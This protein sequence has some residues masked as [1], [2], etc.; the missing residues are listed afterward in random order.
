MFGPS[1]FFQNV[2]DVHSS[3]SSSDFEILHDSAEGFNVLYRTCRNGRFFV[4]K[5]LKPHLRGNPIYEEL[6]RKDFNIGFSLTHQNIVQYYAFVDVPSLGKC[7]V[8]EWIDGCTLEA[9][10]SGRKL[11]DEMVRKI[12]IEICDALDYLHRKQIVHRDL[13]PEN[14]LVTYN[15]SNVKL[16]DFGMSDADSYNVFKAPA[17]TKI[18]ASPELLSGEQID[19]RSDIWSLGV[20]ISEM[21][22]RYSH[23]VSKCLRRNREKRFRNAVEVRNSVHNTAKRRTVIYVASV[24][25][26][27]LLSAGIWWVTRTPVTSSDSRE[28]FVSD[29][30]QEH[31]TA[32]QEERKPVQPVIEEK[33]VADQK[34][35]AATLDDLF[36]EASEQIL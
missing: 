7:I 36:K 17:G 5:A 26:V 25:V 20:I 29:Q 35:D 19:G 15:G 34:I 1:G 16:L 10:I 31:E 12:I 6:L 4:Y 8:M 30:Q 23:L 18:Y 32:P 21:S 28:T 11:S 33:K 2:D 27:A 14:I 3:I 9:L 13:K 24:F 22:T